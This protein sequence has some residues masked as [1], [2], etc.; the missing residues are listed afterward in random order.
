MNGCLGRVW[1][2]MRAKGRG[3]GEIDVN[4]GWKIK[5]LYGKAEWKSWKGS[6]RYVDKGK[7]RCNRCLQAGRLKRCM[8]RLDGSL[9][10]VQE[11]IETKERIGE[12]E[13]DVYSGWKI[14]RMDREADW[15][16]GKGSERDVNEGK[17]RR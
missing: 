2:D 11:S 14:K 13:I 10:L 15:N 1:K 12:E 6:G 17:K 3:E 7:R 8:E 4:I 16:S 5:R 9:V